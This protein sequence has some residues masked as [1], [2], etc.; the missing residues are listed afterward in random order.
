MKAINRIISLVVVALLAFGAYHIAPVQAKAFVNSGVDL[1]GAVLSHFTS[2]PSSDPSA[3]KGLSDLKSLFSSATPAVDPADFSFLG[4]GADGKPLR[5]N[6]CAPIHVIVNTNEA[7]PGALE[8]VK[9]ALA[10]LSSTSGLS[11]VVDGPTDVIP[12][13]N[14]YSTK[15][16][17]SDF[18]PVV[19]AWAKTAESDVFSDGDESGRGGPA[20]ATINGETRYVTG[21]VILN[22]EQNSLYAPGF[23]PGMTR[24]TLLLHE[25]GHLVGLNHAKDKGQVMYPYTGWFSPKDYTSADLAGLNQLGSARGCAL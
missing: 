15:W 6:P 9:Q 11:F 18:P 21:E 3:G 7:T 13:S 20:Y 19:I 25:L 8:D 23:G 12:Q 16:Q 5:W 1:F 14:W 17:G 22:S 2:Q 4:E 24:G 10:T